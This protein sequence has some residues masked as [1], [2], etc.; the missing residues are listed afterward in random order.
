M[1]AW[2]RPQIDASVM[3]LVN[4]LS[5]VSSHSRRSMI[6][7]AFSVPMRQGV[8]WPQLSSSKKR[9]RLS[10]T[11]R[12]SSL[13]ERTTTAAEPMKQPCGSSVPKSR[14]MLSI[15]AGRMPPEAPPGRY[16]LS[17]WPSAMPPQYSSMSSRKVMPAGASFTPGFFTR[18]ETEKLRRPLRPLRPWLANDSGP[19]STM[20]RTQ[21]SVSTLLISVG[22]PNRPTWLGNG[23]LWRGSPRLPSIDSSIAD[24]SPQM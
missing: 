9:M 7:T 8:H 10:A 20:S 13:S 2:P 1:A 11:S 17:M 22:R 23:G 19:F 5:R 4:S 24:S 15:D 18:P 12:M 16:P 21:N 3:T 14:G 6:M